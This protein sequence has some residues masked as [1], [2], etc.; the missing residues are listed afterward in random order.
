M[1]NKTRKKSSRRS[2]AQLT[3]F[4]WE[5]Q[6]HRVLKVVRPA[7]LVDA[8][9]FPEHKRVSMLYS[10]YR[11]KAKP[12]FRNGEAAKILNLSTRT[13]F[14]LWDEGHIHRPP[15]S[16]FL[17]ENDNPIKEWLWWAEENLMEA[18]DYM[19]TVHRG[20]PRKDGEVTVWKDLPSK[21]EIRARINHN[22]TL[23]IK[24]SNGEFVPLFEPPKF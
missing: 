15:T 7:N 1:D 22:E 9:N 24:G 3:Y 20:A 21:A 4:F 19:M 23:Y 5:G 2:N 12:A 17:E 14:K 11:M 6:L 13:L 10:D 16:Y 8:W 18:H